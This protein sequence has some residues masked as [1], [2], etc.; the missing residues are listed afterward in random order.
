MNRLGECCFLVIE[1]PAD[2]RP[3]NSCGDGGHVV[4]RDHASVIHA[5]RQIEKLRAADA[6]LDADIRLL[7]RQLEG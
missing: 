2:L 3:K 6:E 5:V 4:A 7:M 1:E